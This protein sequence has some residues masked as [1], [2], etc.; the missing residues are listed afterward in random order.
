MCVTSA[1]CSGKHT[2][3]SGGKLES[4]PPLGALLTKSWPSK[5]S[6]ELWFSRFVVQNFFQTRHHV[7]RELGHDI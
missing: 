1:R 6:L 5:N 2:K 3:T 7:I 4:L